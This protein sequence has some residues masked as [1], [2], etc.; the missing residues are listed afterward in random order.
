MTTLL[1]GGELSDILDLLKSE[2]PLR[3]SSFKF[4]LETLLLGLNLLLSLGL[5]LGS[6]LLDF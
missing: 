6:D 4:L 5:K 1:L 2:F 3:L